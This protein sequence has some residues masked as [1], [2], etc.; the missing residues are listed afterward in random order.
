[1]ATEESGGLTQTAAVKLSEM[2]E[3]TKQLG[4][5]IQDPERQRG[6]F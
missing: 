5:A 1:M 6:L 2:G 4:N 3:R